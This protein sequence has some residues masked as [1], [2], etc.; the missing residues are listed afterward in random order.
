MKVKVYKTYLA[1]RAPDS[2]VGLTT[3]SSSELFVGITSARGIKDSV[4]EMLFWAAQE[5]FDDV[6]SRDL[7]LYIDLARGSYG[8]LLDD[9]E[10]LV[11]NL[12]SGLMNNIEPRLWSL[13]EIYHT[14]PRYFE[15]ASAALSIH[16][17]REKEFYDLR[18]EFA[19]LP[20]FD[21][22]TASVSEE[23]GERHF[24][25]LRRLMTV[26]DGSTWLDTALSE[27][28]L[29]KQDVLDLLTPGSVIIN[30][31]ESQ[32]TGLVADIVNHLESLDG[33]PVIFHCNIMM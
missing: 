17:G 4:S 19:S 2:I 16:K 21:S 33:S 11:E 25:L 26:T 24:D 31:G 29:T 9:P 22:A 7:G 32:G 30:F 5:A 23:D 15:L 18:E 1:I 27:V 3:N 13:L 12:Q 6:L 28:T 8:Q 10:R 14:G 20:Q